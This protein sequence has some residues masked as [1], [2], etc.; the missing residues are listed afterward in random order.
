MLVFLD[1]SLPSR[2]AAP[3]RSRDLLTSRDAASDRSRDFLFEITK[4][5]ACVRVC[6][7]RPATPLFCRGAAFSG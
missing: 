1:L 3:E 6:T 5:G 4:S 7:R 2:V